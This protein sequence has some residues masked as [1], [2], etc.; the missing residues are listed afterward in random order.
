MNQNSGN[1]TSSSSSSSL[2]LNQFRMYENELPDIDEYV[3][4]KVIKVNNFQAIVELLEYNNKSAMILLSEFSRKRVRS[5]HRITREGRLE[6]LQ[7]LNVDKNRGYVDLS[8]KDVEKKHET[9]CQEKYKKSKMVHN[10]FLY[11]SNLSG[12]PLCDLYLKLGFILAHTYG[13]TFDGLKKMVDDETIIDHFDLSN[14]IKILLLKEIR[15]QF[16]QVPV[17]CEIIINVTCFTPN[18]IVTIKNAFKNAIVLLKNEL[19]DDNDNVIKTL[20]TQIISSPLYS[21]TLCSLIPENAFK[22]L[23]QYIH[24]VKSEIEANGGFLS[25]EKDELS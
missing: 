6:V 3:M 13:N 15:H 19:N 21:V 20:K 10:I 8:K 17:K 16:I 14:E 25:I 2:V 7:V 23:K 18:G 22:I 9:N 11:V 1:E 12:C 4:V 5:A 24:F